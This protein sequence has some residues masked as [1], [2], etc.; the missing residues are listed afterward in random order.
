MVTGLSSSP[1][2]RFILS[3]KLVPDQTCYGRISSNLTGWTSYVSARSHDYKVQ[4]S[5]TVEVLG[6]TMLQAR[7]G[8]PEV[9]V[10]I[11][12]V[13]NLAFPIPL[14][15]S[16]HDKAV[17][18]IFPAERKMVPYNSQRVPILAMYEDSVDKW[19]IIENINKTD[20]SLLSMRT[21]KS[22]RTCIKSNDT[23]A[24]VPKRPPQSAS[25]GAD[26]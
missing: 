17:K 25:V 12:I 15:T 16:F 2:I 9:G 7:M 10:V 5:E 26:L 19:T 11:G 14:G 4:R 8:R 3:L 20:G 18:K 1:M 21:K 24:D 22:C 13:N 6:N 23:L